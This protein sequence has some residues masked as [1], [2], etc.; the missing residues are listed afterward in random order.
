LFGGVD[1]KALPSWLL[2]G[3]S[4]VL[5]VAASLAVSWS[6]VGFQK[7]KLL[8]FQYLLPMFAFVFGYRLEPSQRDT[9]I[10]ETG[11]LVAVGAIVPLQL[12]STWMYRA[13]LHG[14]FYNYPDIITY[15][16][17]LSAAL[18][19][20]VIFFSIYQHLQYVPCVLV[21]AFIFTLFSLWG[22]GRA[23]FLLIALTPLVGVYAIAS[24]SRLAVGAYLLGLIGFFVDSAR[25]HRFLLPGLFLIVSLLLPT[26]YFLLG[27][28]TD[29]GDNILNAK[30]AFLVGENDRLTP[31]MSAQTPATGAQSVASSTTVPAGLSP[32]TAPSIFSRLGYWRYYVGRI[33][34]SPQAF[35]FG[36]AKQPDMK[37]IPSA[38]NY[39]LDFVYNFG[40][41]AFLP[42]L[43][44]A[45]ATVGLILSARSFIVTSP[46]LLGLT[47]S[48]VFLVFVDNSFKVGMR[49]LYP[50]IASFFLWG[51]LV[52]YLQPLRRLSN[53]ESLAAYLKTFR[54]LPWKR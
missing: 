26:G 50:G 17:I 24:T 12:L 22:Q 43:A 11:I 54:Y 16:Q 38:H 48:V 8:F 34:E 46:K 45:S 41:L 23:R 3:L 37:S 21:S 52:N 28:K 40:V 29:K 20:N 27:T 1:K 5:M 32:T 39:Y 15:M 13:N 35:F 53:A 7:W 42:I 18:H 10:P 6:P 19:E 36:H 25:D 31:T 14:S 33:T 4:G 51:L 30:F 9:H 49:Q 2:V 47:F 44:A